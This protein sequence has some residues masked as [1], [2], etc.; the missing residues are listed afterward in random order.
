MI[1]ITIELPLTS[2]DYTLAQATDIGRAVANNALNGL[3]AGDERE[4]KLVSV[5][6]GDTDTPTKGLKFRHPPNNVH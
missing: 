3:H 4:C 1:K 6:M 5:D 2:D